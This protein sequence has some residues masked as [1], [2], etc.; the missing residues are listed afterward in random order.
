MR[1]D[2]NSIV[3]VIDPAFSF[4]AYN[5]GIRQANN[6]CKY[7]PDKE[8]LKK[9]FLVSNPVAR[10]LYGIPKVHKDPLCTE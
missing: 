10:R 1:E 3:A 7:L 6:D 5:E 2:L 4:S 9:A 8:S